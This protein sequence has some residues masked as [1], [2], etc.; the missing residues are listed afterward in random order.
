M[1]SINNLVKDYF[2]KHPTFGKQKLQN[3]HLYSIFFNHL[4][5]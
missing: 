4:K 5:L 1:V 3:G 2:I